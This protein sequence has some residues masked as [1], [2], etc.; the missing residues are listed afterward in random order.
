MALSNFHSGCLNRILT[1]PMNSVYI[2][3]MNSV[4]S[5]YL[6]SA[7][8]WST[9][10]CKKITV[11]LANLCQ[12]LGNFYEK[13]AENPPMS[14]NRPKNSRSRYISQIHSWLPTHFLCDIRMPNKL[15]FS[16]PL[17]KMTRI[18][19]LR[20]CGQFSIDLSVE[21]HF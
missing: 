4:Y 15:Y 2:I 13:R 12:I 17:I 3:Y 18:S 16:A 8:Y 11:I 7:N 10:D 21:P 14:I 6:N 19:C 9:W 20:H 5:I 1:V